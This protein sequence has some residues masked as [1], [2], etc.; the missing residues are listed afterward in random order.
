MIFIT[1]PAYAGCKWKCDANEVTEGYRKIL[2]REIR[3]IQLG[4]VRAVN[5]S[6]I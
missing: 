3:K 2:I 5:F 4:S 6:E 1:P